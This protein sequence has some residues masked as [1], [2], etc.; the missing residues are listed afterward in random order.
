VKESA[1]HGINVEQKC[2][3]RVKKDK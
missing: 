2:F 1:I 3:V